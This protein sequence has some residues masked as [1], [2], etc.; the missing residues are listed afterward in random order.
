MDNLCTKITDCNYDREL[1]SNYKELKINI[2]Y[3]DIIFIDLN[4][5]ELLTV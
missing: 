2:L 4:G 5:D 3:K 1:R